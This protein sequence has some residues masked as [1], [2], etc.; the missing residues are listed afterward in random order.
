MEFSPWLL[1]NDIGW[2]SVLLIVGTIIRAKVRFVQSMF[3]PASIIAGI[4]AL[5]AGPNG[6]GLIPFSD[7]MGTYPS[8]LIAIIFG[9]LPLVSPKVDWHA[10][11]TRVGSMWSYSQLVMVL[12]W[13][14]G[15]LF[16]FLFINPFWTDIHNGFGLLLA[17]GFIGGHGTA[18]AIGA[19]FEQNGWPEATSL[20]MT[21][22]TIGIISSILIGI[23]LIKRGSAKGQT[24][25]LASF[26]ELPDELRTGLI[27][28]ESRTKSETDT[29][30]SISIDPYIFHFALVTIIAMCG[31]YL[32]KLGT[33]LIPSVVIPVFSLAFLAG[34]LVKQ[35]LNIT[36]T[37]K[38]VSKDVVDRI[39]G[40]ATDVLVAF[41]IGSISISAVIDYALPLIMLFVFGLIYAYLFFSVLSRKFFPQYW[42]ERGIFTWGWTT[43]TVAMGIA[44]LRIV[45]SKSESKTLDD[46]ALAYIPIAPVEILLVTF[47]PLF[48]LNQHGWSFILLTLATSIVIIGM[49]LKNGWLRLK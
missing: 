5:M 26:Q 17:S 13:G 38:Y 8:I 6:I 12:M 9:S 16:A 42:F 18:A 7:Q 1:F 23:L 48:V 47:A 46:Y 44:L 25:L 31:Y 45:D 33:V 2:I 11:K 35:L 49:A 24:S 22:A 30:S 29:V 15:L 43:G 27:P 20:A 32:S 28:P 19:T 37:A 4:L 10:I 14:M 21:S 34:L 3:L 41:G 36:N 39:S 40:S